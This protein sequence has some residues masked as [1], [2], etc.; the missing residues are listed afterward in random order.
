[1]SLTLSRKSDYALVALSEL[2]R[3]RSHNGGPM[4]ARTLSEQF[5]LPHHLLTNV[6]KDLHRAD[7]VDSR[8]GAQGG[9]F[10]SRHPA[11][12]SL[13]E[14]IESLEG[15]VS[16]TLCAED[17]EVTET[18]D[19][20]NC[21]TC[22]IHTVC[23]IS[24]PMQKLNLLFRDFLGQISLKSLVDNDAVVPMPPVGVSV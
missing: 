20:E 8:R 10:L 2:V 12:I 4:S 21:G 17:E 5:S 3:A 22:Q 13:K 14:I 6:L 19:E 23:P 7:I 11:D 18:S 1:M 24:S 15:P 16:V 9:Y